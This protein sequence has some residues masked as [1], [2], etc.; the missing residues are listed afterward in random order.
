MKVSLFSNFPFSWR[1]TTKEIRFQKE[2]SDGSR[3]IALA[4]CEKVVS[5]R[6][7]VEA[8]GL[9]FFSFIGLAFGFG[10]CVGGFVVFEENTRTLFGRR[11][12]VDVGDDNE[13]EKDDEGLLKSEFLQTPQSKTNP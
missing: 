13:K 9:N 10:V 2:S 12:T 1:L 7:T 8:Y 11:W 6:N 4:L 5:G 3:V